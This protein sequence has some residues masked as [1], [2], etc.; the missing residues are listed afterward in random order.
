MGFYNELINFLTCNEAEL[1]VG[2]SLPL[3]RKAWATGAAITIAISHLTSERVQEEIST[4]AVAIESSTMDVERKNNL[5][6]RLQHRTVNSVAKASRDAFV[7]T[8]RLRSTQ[9]AAP[10]AKA[11]L[12][13]NAQ[14]QKGK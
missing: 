9:T 3:R 8:W 5:D 2:Y 10:A 14:T 7:R 12:K 1:D 6:K 11:C 4:I 13:K